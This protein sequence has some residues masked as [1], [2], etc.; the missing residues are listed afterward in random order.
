V[1]HGSVRPPVCDLEGVVGYLGLDPRVRQS[2]NGHAHTGRISKEGA[3]LVEHVL[4]EFGHAAVRS[5]G[6]LRAFY[7]RVR[8]RRGHPIAIAK[9]ARKMA[10]LFWHLLTRQQ[11]Y[12]YTLPTAM[13]KRI[14]TIELKDRPSAAVAARA[15]QQ[16]NRDQRRQIERQIAEHTPSRL[17]A[18]RR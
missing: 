8:A 13:A 15:R 14:R 11:D 2:G 6:P 5:P 12:A 17:R 7:L 1:Q 16:L 9:A 18:H 4:V 10:K 3:S